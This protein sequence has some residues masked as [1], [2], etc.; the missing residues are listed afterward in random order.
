MKDQ[1]A[2]IKGQGGM[3]CRTRPSAAGHAIEQLEALHPGTR[4]ATRDGARFIRTNRTCIC[5]CDLAS[6]QLCSAKD[7]YYLH[8]GAIQAGAPQWH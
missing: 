1:S 6:G 3:A 5:F 2:S 4:I 7:L 8:G